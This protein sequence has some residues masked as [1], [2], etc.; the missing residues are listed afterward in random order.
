MSLEP[1]VQS[2]VYPTVP[3][4]WG[5]PNAMFAVSQTLISNTEAY[6]QSLMELGQQIFPPT[7]NANFPVAGGAPNPQI[8]AEPSLINGTFTVPVE[9]GDFVGSINIPA[10]TIPGPFTGLAPTLNFQPRPRP[11]T[12]W[13]PRSPAWT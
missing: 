3:Q 10:G 13:L 6:I 1:P 4:V 9:P 8:P 2:A 12:A 5:D 7:I 11:S